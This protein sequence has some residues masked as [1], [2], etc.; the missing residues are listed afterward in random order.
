MSARLH[1]N[2]FDQFDNG[3][4]QL[5][6][7]ERRKSLQQAERMRVRDE[8]ER[9]HAAMLGDPFDMVVSSKKVLTGI[10]R[11]R[12]ICVRRPAPTRFI[13]FSYF[14]TC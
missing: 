10:L 12:A 6:L 14:C 2:P 13:P 5:S 3:P 4:S 11:P 7:G 1:R 9:R 8:R